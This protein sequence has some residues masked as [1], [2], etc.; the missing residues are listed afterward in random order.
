LSSSLSQHGDDT[1]RAGIEICLREL[2]NR[3]P[4]V[5]VAMAN[6][7]AELFAEHPQ[8]P[9]LLAERLHALGSV[10]V[11]RQSS[12]SPAFAA[13]M[14]EHYYKALVAAARVALHLLRAARRAAQRK[15]QAL[16]DQMT[17]DDTIAD[18]AA[19]ALIQQVSDFEHRDRAAITAPVA[20]FLALPTDRRRRQMAREALYA[21]PARPAWG[22]FEAPPT[23]PACFSS[24]DSGETGSRL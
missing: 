1:Y 4:G 22:G 9:K 3:A 17:I 6:T 13:E 2:A 24:V 10:K 7:V 11:V 5:F 12:V 16:T 8:P 20:F 21:R 14:H 23:W 18:Q 19:G 15:G